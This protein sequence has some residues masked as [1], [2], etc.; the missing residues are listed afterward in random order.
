MDSS[1]AGK[2]NGRA[3]QM[4]R[5]R[6]LLDLLR[7]SL[8]FGL[9][10]SMF[11]FWR[12]LGLLALGKWGYRAAV[13]DAVAFAW[14]ILLVGGWFL[15]ARLLPQVRW[16]GA[17]LA[18]FALGVVGSL[19][20][21][22]ADVAYCALSGGHFNSEGF[23]YL[24]LENVVLLTD[25]DGPLA[26]ACFFGSS[27][28]AVLGLVLD[29][30]RGAWRLRGVPEGRRQR[31]LGASFALAACAL[32]L[33]MGFEAIEERRHRL[34][35][36]AF[37]MH[38][39]LVWRRVLE[40]PNVSAELPR[41]LAERLRDTGLIAA[42]P[43]Y[44]RFPLS[45]ATLDPTPF[46]YP[47]RQSPERGRPN[48]VVTL[49]EQLNREFV[50]A[51]SGELRDVMPE[52]S[53]FA[54]RATMVTEYQST[55]NPTIHALV[56]SVCSVFASSDDR[57]LKIG[58][59]EDK[60][61]LTQASLTCLPKVLKD[62][63]YRTVFIQ[64]GRKEFAGKQDFLVGHGF[65]EMHGLPELQARFPERHV[66]R[67]G[68][69][70]NSLIEYTE[71]QI[72]RLEAQ[73]ERDGRPFF[74][75]MLT[76]DTHSPGLPPPECP[77]PSFAAEHPDGN[78]RSMLHSLHCT[79]AALGRLGRFIT[80][81]PARANSTI[82]AVTG[83]HPTAA[84]QFV[85]RIHQRKGQRYSGWSGRLPLILYD[86]THALPAEV[87]VLS[88]HLDLAPTL[89]HMLDVRDV[90]N[91][92]TGHSIFGLRAKLPM[93]VGR[94]GPKYIA[95][96][97][98]GKTQSMTPGRLRELCDQSAPI[99]NGDAYAL[100]SCELLGWLQLQNALWNEGRI[101]PRRDQH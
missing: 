54:K 98:P 21:R 74:V 4:A 18:A 66:S 57:A 15:L 60:E 41:E 1:K 5:W 63:G 93:L 73:R 44:P 100:S 7:P 8:G 19:L 52:L 88:S 92:M 3:Q 70:D 29:A 90:P 34:V 46:P 17:L 42:Q 99:F 62:L 28:V 96:Y 80:D 6:W 94:Q 32:P 13:T 77:E 53:A 11:W 22:G 81:V 23:L 27:V 55:T 95:L 84:L 47:K 33:A 31:A 51:F 59:R 45:R 75:M 67:W 10:L 69:H 49:V 91:S 50:H 20:V 68:M 101:F 87:P 58:Q 16:R 65:E 78:S 14:D 43:L 36:E 24:R 71:E 39:W 48:V 97:R 83:D 25:G 72:A 35:P 56:A 85:R 38:E 76:L 26:L 82:W 9:T 30:R 12:V 64:G 86:P 37:F 89:L 40:D 2:V 61:A 79:D